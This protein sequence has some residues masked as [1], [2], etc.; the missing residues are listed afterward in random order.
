MSILLAYLRALPRLKG[1]PRRDP[2]FRLGVVT[3]CEATIFVAFA[4]VWTIRA[5]KLSHDPGTLISA[6]SFAAIAGTVFV[7]SWGAL[8]KML[9]LELRPFVYFHRS[10]K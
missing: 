8:L 1:R 5:T 6:W 3:V 9:V 10:T 7:V 4:T 2:N